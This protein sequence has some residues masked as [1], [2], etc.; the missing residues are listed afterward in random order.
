MAYD[1]RSTQT[2]TQYTKNNN[3]NCSQDNRRV[4]QNGA[5][6]NPNVNIN[7]KVKLPL[8]YTE[9]QRLSLE[10]S[11]FERPEVFTSFILDT[12]A[13]AN[14]VT[15]KRAQQIGATHIK[16]YDKY[17]TRGIIEG[18]EV[19]AIGSV[20]IHLKISRSTN[21]LPSLKQNGYSSNFGYEVHETAY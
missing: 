1:D 3:M 11:T 12:G 20:W 16:P 7:N 15:A 8:K 2:R 18:D 17:L 6:Q 19:N 9:D 13:Q 10:L 14:V 4:T 5:T 21:L